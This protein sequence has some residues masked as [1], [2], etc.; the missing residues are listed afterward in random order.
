MSGGHFSYNQYRIEDIVD[1]LELLIK[2]NKKKIEYPDGCSEYGYKFLKSTIKEFKK[3]LKIL[4]NAQVYT[5]R[6]DYL[7][8][9]DDGE[10]SFHKR[11][12][13]ELD[14]IK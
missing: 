2:H 8:C 1:E 4:K 11:L 14:N 6:I 5:Q 12:K 3:G 9:G 7:V 10:E 13:E